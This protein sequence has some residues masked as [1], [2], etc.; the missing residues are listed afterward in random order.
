MS[1]PY[2]QVAD[3]IA[4]AIRAG[5]LQPGD[6]LPPV[7]DLATQRGIS[8]STAQRV[9]KA[10]HA[11]GLV[12]SGWFDGRRGVKVRALGRADYFAT[13]ALRPGRS[14]TGVADAFV[15]NAERIGQT[16]SKRFRMGIEAVPADV[17]RRLGVEPRTFVVVRRTHQLL[18]G[19]PWSRETSYY[20]LDLAQATG[21]DSPDDIEEGCIRRLADAGYREIAHRDEVTDELASPEDAADLGVAPGA[22]LLVQT[23]TAATAERIT[24]VTRVVWIGGHNRLVWESGQAKG[25]AVIRDQGTEDLS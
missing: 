9:M 5:E 2:R 4:A 7:R 20:P 22:P 3:E 19:E 17:A 6:L 8:E 25:I 23:R 10:L 15:E 18:N 12:Y 24:R 1:H 14:R 21:V 11:A 13:D 16:P